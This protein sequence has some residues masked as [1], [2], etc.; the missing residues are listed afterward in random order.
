MQYT[1][2]CQIW[3]WVNNFLIIPKAKA[4]VLLTEQMLGQIQVTYS[5]KK[6]RLAN[7]VERMDM[8]GGDNMEIADKVVHSVCVAPPP[9]QDQGFN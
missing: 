3:H 5:D 7:K 4:T 2:L 9:D 6:E 8:V 1:I